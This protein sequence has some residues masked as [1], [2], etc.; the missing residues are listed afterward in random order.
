MLSVLAAMA[1]GSLHA[2]EEAP[3]APETREHPYVALKTNVA[4]DAFANINL[5]GEVQVA[6]RW[7]L[8]LTGDVNFWKFSDG[9]RWK[10]WIALP[11]A[12]YWFCD[13]GGGSFV[14]AHLIGGQYNIGHVDMDFKLLGTDFG[15]LKDNRFQG[16]MVGAGLGYGYDWILGRHWNLEAEIGLGW[17]YTRYDQYRC[18]GCGQAV[19]KDKPHN[20]FGVTKAAIN[21]VYLF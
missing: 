2:Q 10:H 5:G 18:K 7:S 6:P 16:W 17:V 11:E 9:K 19:T 12:R 8:D 14:A 20:Y 13:V 15:K 4:S 1:A 3:T 21:I